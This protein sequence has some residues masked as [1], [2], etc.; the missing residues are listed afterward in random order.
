MITLLDVYQNG[1]GNPIPGAVEVLYELLR[2]RP[3]EANI[4]HSETPPFNQ[5]E[6][7]VRSKP[8]RSWF[9]VLNDYQQR[10]GAVS[11]TRNNEI[12]IGILK[13]YQRQGYALQALEAVRKF[14]P[15]PR[16]PGQRNGHYLANVAPQNEPSHALFTKAGGRPIQVT[17]E[18]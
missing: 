8:Y 7:F 1:K 15:L 16:V 2:E 14:P 12:G 11:L 18:L 17:Y 13:K 9:L 5:H 6:L 10:V 4:S 3:R